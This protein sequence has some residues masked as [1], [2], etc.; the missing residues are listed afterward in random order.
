[1]GNTVVLPPLASCVFRVAICPFVAL[2]SRLIERRA[3]RSVLRAS[4]TSTHGRIVSSVVFVGSKVY[5]CMAVQVS[6]VTL[7]GEIDFAEATR[8]KSQSRS[9]EA[10]TVA[11]ASK[12]PEN[13]PQ[14][15]EG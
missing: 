6:E 1:V 13:P 8:T 3:E 14:R 4:L 5:S 10:E 11:K 2:T 12:D 9:Q 7:Q 15:K